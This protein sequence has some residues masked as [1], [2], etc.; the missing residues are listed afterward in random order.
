MEISDF[1]LFGLAAYGATYG[2]IRLMLHRRAELLRQFRG[3]MDQG[4]AEATNSEDNPPRSD[5][6]N[7]TPKTRRAA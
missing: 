6:P 7:R 2:L 3:E 4:R 1:V 5:T